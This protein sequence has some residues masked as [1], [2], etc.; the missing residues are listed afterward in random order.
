MR[1]VSFKRR[2]VNLKIDSKGGVKVEPNNILKKIKGKG[3]E[4]T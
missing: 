1:G 4:L 3:F 2:I